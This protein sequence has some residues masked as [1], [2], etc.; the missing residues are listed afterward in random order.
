[1]KGRIYKFHILNTD[2]QIEIQK[3]FSGDRCSRRQNTKDRRIPT[4][5]IVQR[6]VLQRAF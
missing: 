3:V 1:M 5:T 2:G 6:S 4:H